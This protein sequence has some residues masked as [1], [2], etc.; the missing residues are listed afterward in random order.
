VGIAISEHQKRPDIRPHHQVLGH[1]E[2]NAP[3]NL[4]AGSVKLRD[5]HAAAVGTTIGPS[6]RA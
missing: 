4:I 2:P 3:A 5:S 1:V 6:R